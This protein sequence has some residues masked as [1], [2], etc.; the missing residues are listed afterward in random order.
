MF[1]PFEGYSRTV[2]HEDPFIRSRLVSD[3][4]KCFDQDG[5]RVAAFADSDSTQVVSLYHVLGSTA[6]VRNQSPDTREKKEK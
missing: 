3:I 1:I 5:V 2:E 4:E 6:Y